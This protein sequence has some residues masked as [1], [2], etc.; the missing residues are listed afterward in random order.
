MWQL[1]PVSPIQYLNV[2]QAK[3]VEL[4]SNTLFSFC[5]HLYNVAAVL[6]S[7]LGLV[8]LGSPAMLTSV[9][10]STKHAFNLKFYFIKSRFEKSAQSNYMTFVLNNDS[11]MTPFKVTSAA[12]WILFATGC[13][14][15]CYLMTVIITVHWHYGHLSLSGSALICITTRSMHP[16]EGTRH[17]LNWPRTI[18]RLRSFPAHS[19]LQSLLTLLPLYDRSTSRKGI[20]DSRETM[21][22][23]P[24]SPDFIFQ[25]S[26]EYRGE[27]W[28]S[29]RHQGL[30]ESCQ[31]WWF[32]S[33]PGPIGK[34]GTSGA[35][36][37]TGHRGCQVEAKGS[38]EHETA[39]NLTAQKTCKSSSSRGGLEGKRETDKQRLEA[40]ETEIEL[41]RGEIET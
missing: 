32:P 30:R 8:G 11:W 15:G 2:L 22:D 34:R 38:V 3:Y 33:A 10:R 19:S 14:W 27:L 21:E 1:T 18:R 16:P 12:L 25:H 23:M 24:L 29:E 17:P 13:T 4:V 35:A 20:M 40:K 37:V 5:N 6:F 28:D 7:P 39:A 31:P 26:S 41:N 36:W 9:N